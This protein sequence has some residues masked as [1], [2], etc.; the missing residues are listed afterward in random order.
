MHFRTRV[1]NELKIKN[2]VMLIWVLFWKEG[3]VNL[4]MFIIHIYLRIS[5]VFV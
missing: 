3:L 4:K 5:S 2:D 1:N